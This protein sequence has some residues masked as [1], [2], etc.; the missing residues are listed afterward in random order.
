MFCWCTTGLIIS[1][2]DLEPPACAAAWPR[3]DWDPLAP[4]GCPRWG[5][6][7]SFGGCL[8]HPRLLPAA[9]NWG[10]DPYGPPWPKYEELPRPLS[11]DSTVNPRGQ[12]GQNG[13]GGAGRARG[14]SD[15]RVDV[16][17]KNSRENSN[18]CTPGQSFNYIVPFNTF[19]IAIKRI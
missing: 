15:K 13:S 5:A 16:K 14:N 12:Q 19:P 3:W 11:T 18:L 9:L 7:P 8:C 6:A 1:C 4:P 17:C 10:G 2:A